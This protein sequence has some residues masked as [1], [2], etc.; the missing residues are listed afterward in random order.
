MD[1]TNTV[2]TTLDKIDAGIKRMRE[3]SAA[4]RWFLDADNPFSA[5]DKALKLA[6]YM[7]NGICGGEI[8]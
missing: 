6:K 2:I 7:L 8:Q 4:V 5:Y 1:K 3:H